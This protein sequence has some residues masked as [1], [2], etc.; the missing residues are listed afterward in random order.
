MK[1]NPKSRG[2]TAPSLP[3]GSMVWLFL[4]ALA[5][6]VAH[7]FAMRRS[8]Y[9][10]HPIIDAL[11]YHDAARSIAAGHGHPDAVFW[12]PPGYSY[13]LASLYAITGPTDL[14]APRIVQALLGAAAAVATAWIG[15]RQFGPRVGLAAGLI[16]ALYGTLIYFDGE[17][18]GVS[19]TVA[20]Q[21]IAVAL[22]VAAPS[23]VR[24]GRF[25]FGA[26]F[27]AGVASLVTA[28]TLVFAA[29][30]A[31]FARRHAHLVILGAAIAIAPMTIRNAVK[32][33]EIVLISTNAGINLYL[34]NNPRY[35]ETVQIRPD[36]HWTDLTKEPFDRGIRTKSGGSNY[37]AGRAFEWAREDP[38]AFL[39]LQVK[40]LRLLLGGDEIFRNQAIYPSRH[41]SPV[42]SAL[43]WKV[44]GV[45][46]PFGLLAPLAL[47][48]IVVAWRRAPLLAC[49]VA[50]YALAV[51]AFFVAARYRV[52]LVPYLAIF[53]AE[54]VRWF[55]SA[56]PARKA[57]A[58]AGVIAVAAACN[59]GQG[60]MSTRMN[61]DAEY[62]L[63][64]QLQTE[65]RF[66]EAE[67]HYKSALEDR[68]DY[69]EAWVNLGVLEATRGNRVEAAR[70][71]EEGLRLNPKD[72]TALINLAALR[73]REHR[74]EEAI[75]L[76][77]RAA[78]LDPR[79]E[80]PAKRIAY[81]RGLPP[82]Q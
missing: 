39:R 50:A 32:G 41:Y 68:P 12:Q 48:G 15:A 23:A 27:T 62:S 66:G 42:L 81:I 35:D 80:V 56:A 60:R 20:L 47:L 38:I 64:A 11:T 1:K 63:A 5:L 25:W 71:F 2:S 72:S 28:P 3:P 33:G 69:A 37:F 75:Q 21:L 59:L 19:F 45:A 79:D 73:E 31:A 7:L 8:P 26:G 67:A 9:F 61:A 57:A 4:I 54:A 24:P 65:R 46:F 44:P 52:P 30:F 51:V 17:L 53:A 22:A 70:A 82:G 36:R 6:R 14:L 18:L 13:F 29:V 77:Q 34:G 55:I 16:V 58:A 76:Y 10:A 49:I 74:W 78:L 40:K 43:L